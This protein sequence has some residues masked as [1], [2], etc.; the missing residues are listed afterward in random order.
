M[1]DRGV[2][3]GGGR[4]EEERHGGGEGRLFV[5]VVAE[6]E[7]ALRAVEEGGKKD[8]ARTARGPYGDQC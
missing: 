6:E 5:H 2:P 4:K 3:R 8:T 1:I 7:G